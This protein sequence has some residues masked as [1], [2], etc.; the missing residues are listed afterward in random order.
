MTDS[1]VGESARKVV[2]IDEIVFATAGIVLA[3]RGGIFAIGARPA[4]ALGRGLDRG[5]RTRGGS[6]P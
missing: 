3:G 1:V 2:K 5:R 6:E 4:P